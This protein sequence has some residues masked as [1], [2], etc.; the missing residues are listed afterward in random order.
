MAIARSFR[1]VTAVMV[2]VAFVVIGFP[3]DGVLAQAPGGSSGACFDTLARQIEAKQNLRYFS[4]A[5]RE[6]SFLPSLRGPGPY[7]VF[8]PSDEAFESIRGDDADVLN[9]ELSKLISYHIAGAAA[10]DR[11]MEVQKGDSFEV[12]TLCSSCDD[13]R[14]S[15]LQSGQILVNG[16]ARVEDT[17]DT[18]NGLLVVVDAILSPGSGSPAPAP[19]AQVECSSADPT[20]C[21][22]PPP[23]FTCMEQKVWGKCDESWMILGN[24][25]GGYCRYTCGRCGAGEERTFELDP[26][27]PAEEE[28]RRDDGD[29]RRGGGRR[30][31][32]VDPRISCQ[33]SEDGRSGRVDTGRKGCFKINMAEEAAGRYAGRAGGR[34]GE[35]IAGYWGGDASTYASYF[36]GLWSNVAQGWARE[37][38]SGATTNICY[39][40][41]PSGCASATASERFPGAAWRSC[42]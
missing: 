42:D 22:L 37:A 16:D 25:N 7:V 24:G 40:M 14:V 18:C 35:A 8:A 5:L 34:V 20:C 21:D 15:T 9:M 17:L 29:N 13:V 6:S 10:Y 3:V 26:S 41:D 12:S 4:S 38:Y 32:P 19:P 31:T 2:V 39:V 33:C 27:P 11:L 23:E 28:P 36:A 30:I 1:S